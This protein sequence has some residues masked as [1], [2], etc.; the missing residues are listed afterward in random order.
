MKRALDRPALQGVAGVAALIGLTW[1][2]LVFDRP[3]YVLV[4]FFCVWAAVIVLLFVFSRAPE[5]GQA[6]S[7]EGPSD[8]GRDA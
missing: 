4:S 2:L 5:P 3:V 8:G 1:P 7:S 6:A